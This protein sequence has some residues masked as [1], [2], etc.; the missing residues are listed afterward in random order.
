MSKKMR[1]APDYG[2]IVAVVGAITALVGAIA[3]LISVFWGPELTRQALFSTPTPTQALSA[4]P[5]LT[6]SPLSAAAG[7]SGPLSS[8]APMMDTV[9]AQPPFPT[10]SS[11]SNPVPASCDWIPYLNGAAGTPLSNDGCLDDLK[12]DGISGDEKQVSFFI[13]G[14]LVGLYGACRDISDREN[15]NFHIDVRDDIAAA[16]FLITIGPDPIPNQSA[17]GFRV[18][19][20]I[21]RKQATEMYVKFIEY[22]PAGYDKE[23]NEIKAIKEWYSIDEWG[24]DFAFRFTGAQVTAS[25]NKTLMEEWQL[26]S[27]SRYLCFA[28]Q[29]MPTATQSTQLDVHVTS[30]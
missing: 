27:S 11:I 5:A 26:T 28:Y 1:G 8:A 3:T 16:R 18:Q 2:K 4:T 6:T 22:T 19:P 12:G 21:Q 24:F 7:V 9:T 25:M 30:P 13:D 23:V 17:Y 14:A 15:L 20:H 29:A 10:A